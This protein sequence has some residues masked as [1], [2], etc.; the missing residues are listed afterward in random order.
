[1]TTVRIPARFNGP[2][3]SGHGGYS[4]GVFAAQLED[5]P[6]AVSLRAPPPLETDLE[7]V[8]VE[9]GVEIRDGETLVATVERAVPAEDPPGPVDPPVAAAAERP[10][11][12]H[13]FP[14]CYGCGTDREPGDGLRLFAGPLA[15]DDSVFAAR[16]TP[17]ESTPEQVWAAMD[18]PS[19]TPAIIDGPIVLARFCV[20]IAELPEIGAPHSITSRMVREEGRKVFTTVALHD[21][22]GRRLARGDALWIRLR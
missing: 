14:T 4:A 6:V 1:M 19:A 7:V 3:D 9:G 16:W 15:D 13:P 10:Q 17:G 21:A 18:C 11:E 2:P 20:D 22:G 5:G 12:H 8:T